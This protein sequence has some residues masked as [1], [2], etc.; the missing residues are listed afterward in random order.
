[1]KVVLGFDGSEHSK[2]ALGMVLTLL[3]KEDELHIVSVIKEAPRSPEQVIIESEEKAKNSLNSLKESIKEFPVFTEVLESN[4][5]ADS[6]IEYCKK[7][8]CNMIV[9][10]SRGLSGIKKTILGSVS[11]EIM[12]KSDIP[13]LVV[14]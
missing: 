13:V 3:K 1:M 2:K 9:T 14:K 5:V 10:G 6:I 11:S 4:D 8:N 12:N 7:I